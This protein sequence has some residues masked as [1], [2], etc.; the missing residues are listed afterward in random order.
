MVGVDPA[1]PNHNTSFQSGAMADWNDLDMGDH[2]GGGGYDEDGGGGGGGGGGSSENEACKNCGVIGS[3]TYETTI[4]M[5]SIYHIMS[6]H[7]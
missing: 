6:F 1:N 7:P 2:G 3:L 4:G 5:S